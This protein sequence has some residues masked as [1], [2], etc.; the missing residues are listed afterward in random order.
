MQELKALSNIKH[1][2]KDYKAGDVIG[3]ITPEQAAWL[4][5]LGAAEMV[6]PVQK[7]IKKPAAESAGK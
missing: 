2:G 4:V 6:A 3:D 5:A 7:P 1:N